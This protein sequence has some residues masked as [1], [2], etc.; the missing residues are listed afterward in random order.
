M[1][2][3]ASISRAAGAAPGA[4]SE[5]GSER[6][7]HGALAPPIRRLLGPL[8]LFAA[9]L[10]PAPYGTGSAA[11]AVR[12]LAPGEELKVPGEEPY[13]P[14]GPSL[15]AP[16]K[17]QGKGPAKE[18]EKTQDKAPGPEQ[19]SAAALQLP[20]ISIAVA[21]GEAAALEGL[22]AR[23][24]PFDVVPLTAA[25]DLVWDAASHDVSADGK[26]IAFAVPL[27][28]L[29]AVIDRTAV[30]HA[31]AEQAAAHPQSI[32]LAAPNRLF[33]KNE[34]IQI[35]VDGVGGRA[36]LIADIAGDGVTQLIF[37]GGSD[38]PVPPASPYKLGLTTGEPFGT[39]VMVAITAAQPMGKLESRMKETRATEAD[40]FLALIGETAP[41]DLRMGLLTLSTVP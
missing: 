27:G 8:V 19:K 13:I 5:R 33:R 31:L 6:R 3:Q 22:K 29:A 39:D 30:V 2:R 25:A 9:F 28:G 4:R 14:P 37:P 15:E 41:A 10:L 32:K 1:R 7:E 11:A 17:I 24:A 35:L 26:V 21:H 16:D 40:E 20:R 36:L 18:Q 34:A 38:D 12:L 23:K